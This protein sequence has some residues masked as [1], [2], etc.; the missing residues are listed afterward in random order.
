MAHLVKIVTPRCGCGKRAAV[1][2]YNSWN[3][4]MGVFCAPCG[5][6]KLREIQRSEAAQQAKP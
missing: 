5:N 3:A 1:E 2:V 4:R 6:Q